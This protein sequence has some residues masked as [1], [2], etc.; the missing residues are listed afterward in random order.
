MGKP[1]WV[2]IV[3]VAL[4][5]YLLGTESSIHESL[6]RPLQAGVTTSSDKATHAITAWSPDGQEIAQA[7]Y[8]GLL[9]VDT[10]FHSLALLSKEPTSAIAWSPDSTMLA[11][12]TEASNAVEI[13]D[14]RSNNSRAFQGHTSTVTGLSWSPTGQQI[15]SGSTDMTVRI[16]GIS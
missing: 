4:I 10:Q 5:G 6:S 9:I 8:F 1:V 7:G 13:W 12:S 16:W 15:A 3:L 2:L 11:F 14:F